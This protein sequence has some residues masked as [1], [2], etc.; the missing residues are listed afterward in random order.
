MSEGEI[1]RYIE[2]VM[3]MA[4]YAWGELV[5]A[6]LARHTDRWPPPGEGY[7]IPSV[8][9]YLAAMIQYAYNA[10]ELALKDWGS[11][12]GQLCP[13]DECCHVLA[14]EHG[15]WWH[16]PAC[17]RDFYAQDCDSD[18]EDYHCY[19]EHSVRISVAKLDVVPLARDCGPSWATPEGR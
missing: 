3:E 18:Y 13:Y 1:Q 8:A 6:G 4:D 17:G 12:E 7:G 15:G 11:T 19:E 2:S 10:R 14:F 5:K 16:C 9:Y